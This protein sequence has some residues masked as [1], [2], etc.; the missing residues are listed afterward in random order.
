MNHFD[1]WE[2][3][4][5]NR[6]RMLYE[7]ARN[8]MAGFKPAERDWH[9]TR[10]LG[11]PPCRLHEWRTRDR[12]VVV[13]IHDMTDTHLLAA[14][15]MA[16]RCPQHYLKL[17]MLRKESSQRAFKLTLRTPAWLKS[18]QHSVDAIDYLVRGSNEPCP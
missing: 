5:F 14:I 17:D 6:A 8:A 9:A 12:Q 13:R 18:R 4:E 16:E 15:R 10:R 2:D 11:E 1:D 3:P 7:Q